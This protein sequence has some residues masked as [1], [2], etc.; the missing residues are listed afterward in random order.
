VEKKNCI[1]VSF[2]KDAASFKPAFCHSWRKAVKG[3]WQSIVSGNGECVTARWRKETLFS[4][5]L[6]NVTFRS[7]SAPND[8]VYTHENTHPRRTLSSRG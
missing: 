4:S 1:T 6:Q 7:V 8:K 5:S 3:K 2:Y